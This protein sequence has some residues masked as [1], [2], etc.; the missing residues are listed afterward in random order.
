LA[1][2]RAE[3]PDRVVRAEAAMS[4]ADRLDAVADKLGLSADQRKRIAC[5]GARPARRK[6]P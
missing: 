5:R 4:I 3:L 1:S 6:R 2:D